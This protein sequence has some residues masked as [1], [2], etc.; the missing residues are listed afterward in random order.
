MGNPFGIDNAYVALVVPLVIM[1][2]SSMVQRIRTGKVAQGPVSN[3]R[4]APD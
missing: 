1:G 2:F 4:S 3:P